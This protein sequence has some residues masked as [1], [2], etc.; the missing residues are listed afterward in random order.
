M[1]EFAARLTQWSLRQDRSSSEKG[2]LLATLR[3]AVAVRPGTARLQRPRQRRHELDLTPGTIGTLT[4]YRLKYDPASPDEGLFLVPEAG[5]PGVQV[6]AI[7]ANK[8]RS[9]V[10]QVPSALAPGA[11]R[12]EV[13]AR[14]RDSE[15]LRTGTLAA[16]LTV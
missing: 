10:F 14:M 9:I 3:R 4:G 5:G 1:R 15:D 2:N 13:R 11:Y 7:Q 6:T 16:V 12:L 8:P